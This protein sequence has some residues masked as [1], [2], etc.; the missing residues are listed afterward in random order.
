MADSP[1]P[2]ATPS[3]GGRLGGPVRLLG[4]AGVLPGAAAAA[5]PAAPPPP[6]KPRGAENLVCY[7]GLTPLAGRRDFYLR[8][9]WEE[10]LRERKL[11]LKNLQDLH[12]WLFS[13]GYP[14]TQCCPL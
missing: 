8:Y 12:A 7:R 14:S 13:F 2:P 6:R 11:L 3:W 1:A 5:A 4:A 9:S 10:P